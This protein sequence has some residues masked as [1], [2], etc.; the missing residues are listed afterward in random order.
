MIWMAV[1]VL[2]NDVH[3][4][5]YR[6]HLARPIEKNRDWFPL[7]STN[8][9]F[10]F[11]AGTPRLSPQL[12]ASGPKRCEGNKSNWNPGKFFRAFLP[13][14][15]FITWGRI[16]PRWHDGDTKNNDRVYNK[17]YHCIA[18]FL[19]SVPVHMSDKSNEHYGKSSNTLDQQCQQL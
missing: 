7:V 5:K 16:A 12:S 13:D 17:H 19:L 3:N 15:A 18:F 6:Y 1:K 4:E 11:Y 8:L 14:K 10:P 9:L 2:L